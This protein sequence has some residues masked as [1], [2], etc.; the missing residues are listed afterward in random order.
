MVISPNGN[1]LI[2]YRNCHKDRKKCLSSKRPTQIPVWSKYP[3]WA[4]RRLNG[5]I[6]PIIDQIRPLSSGGLSL[7]AGS[8]AVIF[9]P[10]AGRDRKRGG[11]LDLA[12]TVLHVALGKWR[13]SPPRPCCHLCVGEL[14]IQDAA[15]ANRSD[16]VLPPSRR[17]RRARRQRALGGGK[18]PR[19][20]RSDKTKFCNSV[21]WGTNGENVGTC[22]EII[23][24]PRAF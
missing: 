23:A 12:A 3:S 2:V 19:C 24:R 7:V 11:H 10:T 4:F 14:S 21:K 18:R 17:V 6:E 9:W 8:M 15:A 20:G 22:I 1:V 5:N 13:R 16:D